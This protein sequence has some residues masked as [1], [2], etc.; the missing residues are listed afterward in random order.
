MLVV[1][2]TA[3]LKAKTA[4]ARGIPTSTQIVCCTSYRSRADP[5]ASRAPGTSLRRCLGAIASV[6]PVFNLSSISSGGYDA[7]R[8]DRATVV[9]ASSGGRARKKSTAALMEDTDNDVERGATVDRGADGG[10]SL[11]NFRLTGERYKTFVFKCVF[12]LKP[13]SAL[14]LFFLSFSRKFSRVFYS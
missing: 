8:G 4:V 5:P 13:T 10:G 2:R 1:R 3:S 6:I 11:T 14:S 9:T 12:E 7:P